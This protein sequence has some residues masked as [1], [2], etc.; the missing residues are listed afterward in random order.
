MLKPWD[1]VSN[2]TEYAIFDGFG[3]FCG[4]ET[5]EDAEKARRE[6]LTV[7]DELDGISEETRKKYLS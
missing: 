4:Y 2:G 3:F 1:I 7:K 6:I 5:R